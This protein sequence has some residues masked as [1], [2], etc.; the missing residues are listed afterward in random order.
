MRAHV[1]QHAPFEDL[2]SIRDWL[3]RRDACVTTTRFFESP[4]LPAV[5]SLDLVIA[6]GGPM[7]VNNEKDL[8]WLVSEKRFVAEAVSSGKAVLGICLGAQLI[9][10]ALGGLVYPGPEKEI[11]WF[12]VHAEPRSPD[13]FALPD[14]HTVFH[15][16][17]ETFDL[18][19]G[20]RLLAS[21]A[22]CRNQ[23]FQVGP[24]TIGLQFHL[25][26]T[27]GG[28]DALITNCRHELTPQR[29][30]QTEGQLRAV[31]DGAYAGINTLMEE[32]LE[33]LV[34]HAVD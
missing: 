32:V 26:I 14:S 13:S 21:S 34:R 27:P 6:L 4:V 33:Y 11:G 15:W 18:P 29:F 28:A 16:H 24:R 31:P 8:P 23:A 20:A 3:Q 25:E 17:G 22:A 12:S 2:G 19:P 1:L 10:N 9:A 5:S 30:V 7:S